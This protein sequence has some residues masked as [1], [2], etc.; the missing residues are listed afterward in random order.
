VKEDEK[1]N[2]EM[3]RKSRTKKKANFFSVPTM[4]A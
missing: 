3:D 4:K 1:V 2:K